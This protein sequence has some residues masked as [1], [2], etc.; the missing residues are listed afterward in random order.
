MTKYTYYYVKPSV[1]GPFKKVVRFTRGTFRGISNP[2]GTVGF[3]YAIFQNRCGSV[4]IPLHDLT[5]ET[6]AAIAKAEADSD[7]EA[8]LRALWD[9][10]GV[11]RERQ[12]EIIADVTAKAQPGAMVGP[13]VLGE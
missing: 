6:K 2:T 10:K 13:F 4:W 3:R 5:P 7:P 9:A 1:R 8:T 12:D 11:S